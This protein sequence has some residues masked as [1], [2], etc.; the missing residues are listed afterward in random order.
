MYA[1]VITIETATKTNK[2]TELKGIYASFEEAKEAVKD[3][4]SI[5]KGTLADRHNCYKGQIKCSSKK[6]TKYDFIRSTTVL[7]YKSGDVEENVVIKI[8][9]QPMFGFNK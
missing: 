6:G 3:I 5:Q 4:A 1:Y 9:E 7:T 2:T 8:N